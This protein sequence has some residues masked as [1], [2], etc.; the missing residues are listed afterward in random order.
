MR[1][2]KDRE[3]EEELKREYGKKFFELHPA[4]ELLLA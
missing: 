1:G 2:R 3:E 4:R